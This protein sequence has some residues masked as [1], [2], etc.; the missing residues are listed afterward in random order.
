MAATDVVIFDNER[1]EDLYPETENR[2][3]QKSWK[4]L[5]EK[6]KKD[7]ISKLCMFHWTISRVNVQLCCI[8]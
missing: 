5:T 2:N 1:I 3:S 8:I 7:K 6:E 4:V